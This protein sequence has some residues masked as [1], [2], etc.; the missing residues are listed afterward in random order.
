MF[1][2]G[3]VYV[4]VRTGGV[5]SEEQRLTASALGSDAQ[6]GQSVA[7]SWEAMLVGEPYRDHGSGSAFVFRRAGSTWSEEARL[8][9]PGTAS[10]DRFGSA[11][12]LEGDVLVVGAP[13]DDIPE[14][15][16]AGS[17]SVFRRSGAAWTLEQK[18]VASDASDDDHF[19]AAVAISGDTVAV[20]APGPGFQVG[21]AYVFA[22]SGG[23][24]QQ[25]QKLV[26]PGAP[27][28]GFAVS[29]D[30]DSLVVGAPTE[31]EAG[32]NSAG[33]AHVFVRTGSS[34]SLQQRLVSSAPENSAR[35]GFAVAIEG[36]TTMVGVPGEGSGKVLA[37]RRTAGL[38][39]Q[40]GTLSASDGN[41]GDGFGWALSLAGDTLIVGAPWT[42][43]QSVLY[44]GAGYV[45]LRSGGLWAEQHKLVAAQPSFLEKLGASV[46]VYG[47]VALVASEEYP[48][49]P[50]GGFALLFER[51]GGAWTQRQ[52]ITAVDG[53][54][55]DRFGTAVA[56]SGGTAAGA[57]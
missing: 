24:W 16:Q 15:R 3:A 28:F 19:G 44:A 7:I 27:D 18:I 5:W 26:A 4:F 2:A 11:V 57:V 14:G 49:G 42:E 53:V 51:T 33:A 23:V 1:R 17:V 48:F 12:T 45:F 31:D 35:V 25:Q 10:F 6:F 56:L 22:R 39:T 30:G 8:D 9:P 32:V 21:A 54:L 40:E 38:W 36:D 29:V 34:W 37:F 46:A 47:D 43:M 13:S 41:P 52:R 20:G 50:G 55:D